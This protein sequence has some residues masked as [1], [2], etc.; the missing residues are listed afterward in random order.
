MDA[1]EVG[2]CEVQ[3]TSEL[4]V[5]QFLRGIA[6]GLCNSMDTQYSKRL[7]FVKGN[8][9]IDL[10]INRIQPPDYKGNSHLE[11]KVHKGASYD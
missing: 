5:V 10:F 7:L 11:S 6:S 1:A 4:E 2:M 8:L 3:G 9:P